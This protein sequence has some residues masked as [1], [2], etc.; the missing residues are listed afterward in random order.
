MR[1]LFSFQTTNYIYDTGII[2]GIF[3][4]QRSATPRWIVQQQMGVGGSYWAHIARI[5]LHEGTTR[6]AHHL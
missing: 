4:D 1:E 2:R 5:E 3:D 6:L